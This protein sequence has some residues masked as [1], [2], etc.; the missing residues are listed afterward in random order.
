MDLVQDAEVSGLIDTWLHCSDGLNKQCPSMWA[1][2]SFEDALRWAYSDENGLEVS[3]GAELS[4][5]YF[6][7][8]ACCETPTCC[9]GCETWC[10]S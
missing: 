8:L 5:D 2:E 7:P 3:D 4:D 9:S 10:R 1:E 6:D